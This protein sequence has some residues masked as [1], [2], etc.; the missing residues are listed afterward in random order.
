MRGLAAAIA[1]QGRWLLIAG[2][3]VGLAAEAAPAEEAAVPAEEASPAEEESLAF[4]DPYI[5]SALCTSCND[6]MKVNPRLFVYNENKQ[7]FFSD[8]NAGTYEELVRAAER[9]Q[10]AVI[11]P[12]KPKN[13][14]EPNLEEL[15]KRAE[16]FNH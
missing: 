12:G 10:L 4:D 15:I 3:A 11:H 14:D 7:A 1:A 16:P 9:C 2:L 5:D 13:P 8:I 6:C